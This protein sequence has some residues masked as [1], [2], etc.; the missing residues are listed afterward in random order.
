[1]GRCGAVVVAGL[2]TVSLS[3]VDLFA[4]HGRCYD[5]EEPPMTREREYQLDGGSVEKTTHTGLKTKTCR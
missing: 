3:G 4:S 1:M 2:A 5:A